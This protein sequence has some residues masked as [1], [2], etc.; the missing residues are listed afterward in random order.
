M[1]ADW[2]IG[3]NLTPILFQITDVTHIE[4]SHELSEQD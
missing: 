2:M 1:Y 3:I 4:T